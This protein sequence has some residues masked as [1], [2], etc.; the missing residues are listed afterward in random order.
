MC[1]TLLI[2]SVS[3]QLEKLKLHFDRDLLKQAPLFSAPPP[4][5]SCNCGNSDQKYKHFESLLTS[6]NQTNLSL[7]KRNEEL[8]NQLLMLLIQ[9]QTNNKIKLIEDSQKQNT[10]KKKEKSA[11]C[12]IMQLV[13]ICTYSSLNINL[14]TSFILILYYIFPTQIRTIP[15]YFIHRLQLCPP[16]KRIEFISI[17]QNC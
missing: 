14:N 7:Q 6:M 17:I 15:R 5:C 3:F 1:L 12:S 10:N 9:S 2:V 13:C 11:L 4:L 16:T 8:T